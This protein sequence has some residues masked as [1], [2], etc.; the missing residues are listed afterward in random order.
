LHTEDLSNKLMEVRS[1]IKF[2]LK[3]VLCLG[4]TPRLGLLRQQQ[5]TFG[6]VEYEFKVT[7]TNPSEFCIVAQDT[8]IRTGE[9]PPLYYGV[10]NSPIHLTRG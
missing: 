2:Q 7:E 5:A 8:V 1:T 10:A 3:K 4:V 9:Y 6:L